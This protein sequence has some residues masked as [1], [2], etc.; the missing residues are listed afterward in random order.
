VTTSATADSSLMAESQLAD[1]NSFCDS[2]FG[3]IIQHDSPAIGL[4]I[5]REIAVASAG[6]R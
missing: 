3:V 4:S 2:T 6:T 5:V 1:R